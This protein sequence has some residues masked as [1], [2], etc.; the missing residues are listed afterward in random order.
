MKIN[1]NCFSGQST[2]LL[3]FDI[4]MDDEPEMDEFVTVEIL[5]IEPQETQ[6]IKP[7]GATVEIIILENDNPGGTFHFSEETPLSYVVQVLSMEW[8]EVG[9]G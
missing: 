3:L 8:R 9:V 2:A 7:G 4:M 5:H 1:V 6:R